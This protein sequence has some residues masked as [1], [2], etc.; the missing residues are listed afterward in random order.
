MMQLKIE[1]AEGA[2]AL[3]FTPK[4]PFPAMVQLLMATLPVEVICTPYVEFP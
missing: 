4:V 2:A 3:L 1:V